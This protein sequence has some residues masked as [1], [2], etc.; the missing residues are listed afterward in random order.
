[1]RMR[2]IE[3]WLCQFKDA[4]TYAN[5]SHPENNFAILFKN[6]LKMPVL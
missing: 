4:F 1:M 6:L 2:A 3:E 5:D